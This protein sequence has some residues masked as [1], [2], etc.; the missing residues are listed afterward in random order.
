[1]GYMR[2]HALVVTSWK[3]SV[4]H[5]VHAAAV[6]FAT[7]AGMACTVTPIIPG[8][9]NG[10]RTF[11]VCSDGSKEGWAESDAGDS[12]RAAVIKECDLHLYSDG[13]SPLSWVLV[14]YGDDDHDTRVVAHSEQHDRPC[15]HSAGDRGECGGDG[16]GK[17]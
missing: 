6:Q 1:M 16:G 5:A 14:Q 9:V 11:V 12:V 4:L 7:D 15:V 2:H 8:T 10:I 13:S 17:A 3:D